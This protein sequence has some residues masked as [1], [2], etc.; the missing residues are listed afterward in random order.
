MSLQ[1][2]GIL[3]APVRAGVT[4]GSIAAMVASVVNLPLDAPTDT[5]FNAATVTF[6]VTARDDGDVVFI[7]AKTT[8]TWAQLQLPPPS[9]RSVVSIEDDI[10]VEVLL[11]VRP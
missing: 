6:D 1:H 3:R 5:L 10:R 8:V 4:A 2:C 11:V 9:A 7:L